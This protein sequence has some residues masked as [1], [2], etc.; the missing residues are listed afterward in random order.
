MKKAF[1][2]AYLHDE[3]KYTNKQKSI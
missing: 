2:P 1:S 3:N